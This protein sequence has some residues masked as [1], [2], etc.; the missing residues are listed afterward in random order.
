MVK[1]VGSEWRSFEEFYARVNQPDQ[2]ICGLKSSETFKMEHKTIQWEPSLIF[3]L[4]FN[5]LDLAG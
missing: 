3:T 5:N 4:V 1:S 2:S